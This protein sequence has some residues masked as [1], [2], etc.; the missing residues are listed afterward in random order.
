MP[1]QVSDMSLQQ[2]KALSWRLDD[3]A[4]NKGNL[5]LLTSWFTRI[6][7]IMTRFPDSYRVPK[8]SNNERCCCARHF[9]I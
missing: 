6:L 8:A 5:A 7:L 2:L 3:E 9:R 4:F 1:Q